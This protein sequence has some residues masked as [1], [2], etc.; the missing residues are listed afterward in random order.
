MTDMEEFIK[1]H[2]AC[3]PV[4]QLRYAD[5]CEPVSMRFEYESIRYYLYWHGKTIVRLPEFLAIWLSY[6]SNNV[7]AEYINCKVVK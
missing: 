7:C 3:L 2:S 6:H 5:E 4:G 1:K